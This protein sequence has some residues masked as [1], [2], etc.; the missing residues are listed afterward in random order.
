MSL[1]DEARAIQ[2]KTGTPCAMQRI[3]EADPELY[4]EFIEA[5][6]SDLS[7]A[8]I[9]QAFANRKHKPVQISY[10]ILGRHRRGDCTWC[11]G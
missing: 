3:K 4:A 1:L 10:Q 6:A 8:V 7:S 11:N 9:A 5:L 2:R